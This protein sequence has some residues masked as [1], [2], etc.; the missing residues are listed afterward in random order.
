MVSLSPAKPYPLALNLCSTG[1][2]AELVDTDGCTAVHLAVAAG[3]QDVVA[4]L[5]DNGALLVH[6]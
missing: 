2:D 6:P 3:H 4:M 1:A 5:N